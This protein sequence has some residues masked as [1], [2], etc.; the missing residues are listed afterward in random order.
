LEFTLKIIPPSCTAQEKILVI[1][2]VQISPLQHP[3]ADAPLLLPGMPAWGG[4]YSADEFISSLPPVRISGCLP[5]RH[6]AGT[7]AFRMMDNR[8]RIRRLS[9]PGRTT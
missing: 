1:S 8:N 7:G 6:P 4:E 9:R 5:V 3:S 2:L